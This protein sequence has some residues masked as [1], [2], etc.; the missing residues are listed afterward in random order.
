MES[1]VPRSA[2]SRH[3]A[4]LDDY[5][6][7]VAGLL[8]LFEATGD[9]RW[10]REA[11]ALDDVLGRHYEDKESGGYFLTSDDHEEL[12]AREKPGYDGAEPSGNSVQALNLLRFH[13]LTTTDV[14]RRRPSAPSARSAVL[15]R[16]GRRHCPRCFWH[17]TTSSTPR[18]RS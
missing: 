4:Y 2:S 18:R 3:A 10:L 6:F 5:A 16:A 12:L 1:R 11:L 13:E 15:S 9:P 7:F 8:D 14:Y 17:S